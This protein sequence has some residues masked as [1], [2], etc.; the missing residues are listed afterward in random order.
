MSTAFT[1]TKTGNDIKDVTIRHK[2][3]EKVVKAYHPDDLKL[4]F[5]AAKQEESITFQFFLTTGAREQEVMHACWGDIDFKDGVFTIR[6]HPEWGFTTKDH[7]ERDI[8]LPGHIV[9]KLKARMRTSELIFPSKQGR[10]NGHF[11]K[12]PKEVAERAG[13]NPDQCGLH[14]CLVAFPFSPL[15]DSRQ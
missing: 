7:E 3:T 15:G 2:Y 11:L 13:V 4:L 6:D 12:T 10:P 5:C 14:W 8:P 9:E 1:S